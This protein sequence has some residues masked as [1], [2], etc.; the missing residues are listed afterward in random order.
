MIECL[1]LE[2]IKVILIQSDIGS[3]GDKSIADLVKNY[4]Y[5]YI[6]LLFIIV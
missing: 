6:L 2:V 4:V 5:I 3:E 1:D